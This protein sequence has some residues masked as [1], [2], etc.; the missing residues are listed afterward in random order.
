M[1]THTAIGIDLGSSRFVIGVAKKGGVEI[2]VNEASYRQTPCL[3]SFGSERRVGDRAF[4]HVKKELKNSIFF[5][6]RLLGDVNASVL[7]QEEPFNYSRIKIREDARAQ[8]HINYEGEQI[9]VTAEQAVAALFTE[10]TDIMALNGIENKEAVVS[11]PAYFNQVQRQAL[12][13]AAKIAGIEVVKL[14][15]ESSATVMNYGI[16]RKADLSASTPRTVAFVD[17]GHSK[18]SVYVANI[19]NDRAEILLEETDPNAGVRNI[20]LA[21]LFFYLDKFNAKYKVDLSDNPKALYRLMEAIEKQRKILTANIEAALSIECLYEDIDFTYMMTREEFEK[22]AAKTLTSLEN[23]LNKCAQWLHA[24][25]NEK[26]HSVERIGGGTRIHYVEHLIEKVF[27]IKSV[28]KTLDA[29]ESVARGCTIQAAILSPLFKV[30]AFNVTDKILYPITIKLQYEGEEIK[31]KTLFDTGAEFNKTLSVSI[32][33]PSRLSIGL[34]VPSGT[35]HQPDRQIVDAFIDKI[36][37]KEAKF[38]A[39]VIFFLNKNG[40][41]LVEKA[42][43][44]ETY[45][46]EEKIP[47]KKTTK[48]EEKKDAPN[49]GSKIEVESAPEE[50]FTIEKKEKVRV[51]SIPIQI[52]LLYGLQ[53][54]QVQSMSHFENAIIQKERLVKETQRAKYLLES[55]IYNTRN[56]MS[57]GSNGIFT[58]PVEKEEILKVLQQA[59]NWLYDEGVNTDKETYNKNLARLQDIAKPFYTRFKKIEEATVYYGEAISAFREFESK[60]ADLLAH[61]SPIQ[62]NEVAQKI[63]ESMSMLQEIDNLIKNFSI[64]LVDTFDFEARKNSINKSYEQMN[65]VLS[66]IKRDKENREREE[67]RKQEEEKKRQEEEAKKQAQAQTNGGMDVEQGDQKPSE[68]EVEK[69]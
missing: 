62:L 68:M 53:A 65:N 69:Q 12:I 61:G 58:T 33:K 37:T 59:E 57:E 27:K 8:Y 25:Q 4:A 3:V 35:H 14:Y 6:H 16:F 54:E 51:T 45:I 28:S 13:D 29:N 20:D 7:Q 22:I 44:R 40:M 50:E 26:L 43:L 60:N 34:Y 64:A 32:N 19:W 10:M 46:A 18:T 55:F 11:V 48:P 30:A 38:E 67:K 63:S 5:P 39:K 1:N 47:V 52:N 49:D 9:A 2:I 21:L 41:A 42:E 56:K 24:H 66:M 15:N 17:F 23:V 31:T 36:N